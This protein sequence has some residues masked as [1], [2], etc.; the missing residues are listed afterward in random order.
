MGV[1]RVHENNSGPPMNVLSVIEKHTNGCGGGPKSLCNGA[2]PAWSWW[3][4]W[5]VWQEQECFHWGWHRSE[6]C[7]P[8]APTSCPSS[9]VL[10]SWRGARK[11]DNKL[12]EMNLLT[13]N[14]YCLFVITDFHWRVT[15]K[16][17]GLGF[18][19]CEVQTYGS[20]SQWGPLSVRHN[21]MTVSRRTKEIEERLYNEV[22][23]AVTASTHPWSHHFLKTLT[24]KYRHSV[25]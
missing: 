12:T 21:P 18:W 25:N 19:G 20:R 8:S 2:E 6:S 13:E 11:I 14:R 4:K 15:Y 16:G 3:V 10:A 22:T 23:R 24:F 7:G 9:R 17:I 1:G 5:E